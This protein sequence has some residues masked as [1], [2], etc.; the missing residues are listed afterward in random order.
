MHGEMLECG[1]CETQ[2]EIRAA[3]ETRS[4]IDSFATAL[5][6]LDGRRKRG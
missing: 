3:G 2:I 5:G 1:G 6:T 4:T